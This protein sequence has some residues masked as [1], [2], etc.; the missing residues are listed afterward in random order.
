[1]RIVFKQPLKRSTGKL[2]ELRIDFR[3]PLMNPRQQLIEPGE[4]RRW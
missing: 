1:V 2:T 4:R 3:V